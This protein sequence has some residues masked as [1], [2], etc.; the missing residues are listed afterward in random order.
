MVALLE[1]YPITEDKI[2]LSQGFKNGFRLEYKGPRISITTKKLKSAV[3]NKFITREKLQKEVK[4]ERMAGSFPTKPISTLRT[5]AIGIVP[6]HD[7]GWRLIMHFSYSPRQGVNSFIDQENC[8]VQYSSFDEIV[9]IVSDLGKGA[10]LSQ[11]FGYCQFIEQI[12]IC[13]LFSLRN[14]IM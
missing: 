6:K 8:S 12:L 5:S 3:E 4:L 7:G 9:S 13:E 2:K 14:N 11:L 1:N 10:L